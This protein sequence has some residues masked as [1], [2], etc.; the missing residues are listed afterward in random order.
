M[1]DVAKTAARV[2]ARQHLAGTLSAIAR[3]LGLVIKEPLREAGKARK[4][5][6]E[7]Q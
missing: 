2:S 4:K 6:C 5:L 1:L 7:R 3:N